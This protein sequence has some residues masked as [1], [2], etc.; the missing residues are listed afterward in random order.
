VESVAL[1]VIGFVV[2]LVIAQVGAPYFISMF[3]GT[4]S[5][6]TGNAAGPLR[7]I[8]PATSLDASLTSDLVASSLLLA[9]VLGVVGALYPIMASLKLKPAEALRHDH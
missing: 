6:T 5:T 4:Q 2:G 8:S 3:A 1:A 7:Q 9:V